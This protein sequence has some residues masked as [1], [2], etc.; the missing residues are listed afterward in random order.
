MQNQ[1]TSG[2][3]Q[4]FTSSLGLAVTGLACGTVATVATIYGSPFVAIAFAATGAVALNSF[5]IKGITAAKEGNKQ[6]EEK[7][8]QKYPESRINEIHRE[9]G[10]PERVPQL[11]NLGI[12]SGVVGILAA[13]SSAAV[14]SVQAT[15]QDQNDTSLKNSGAALVI[16]GG[17]AILVGF[18]ALTVLGNRLGTIKD[19]LLE[20]QSLNQNSEIANPTTSGVELSE[21]DNKSSTT[22]RA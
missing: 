8:K 18:T 10:K 6:I 22:A 19:K 2:W 3:R 17:T 13:A 15:L 4:H 9:L 7:L 20:P 12:R 16:T 1:N 14:G 21:K 5:V 11:V